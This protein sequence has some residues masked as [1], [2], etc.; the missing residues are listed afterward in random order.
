MYP[1]DI[2]KGLWHMAAEVRAAVSAAG[3]DSR[4][5]E[6]DLGSAYAA[7][8]VPGSAQVLSAQLAR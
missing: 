5:D 1:E 8:D 7:V 6:W 4:L 3:G 2:P